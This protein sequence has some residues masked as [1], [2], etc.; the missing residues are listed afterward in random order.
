M[1]S[2]SPRVLARVG[3]LL[4]LVSAWF[5][6][7]GLRAQQGPTAI[8]VDSIV[9]EGNERVAESSILV[10]IPFAAGDTISR[11]DIQDAEQ[12]LWGLGQFDDIRVQAVGGV[13]I[14][15]VVITFVVEERPLVRRV[16]F[17]GLERADAGTVRD[18]AGLADGRPL[19]P[20]AILD[21]RAVILG[22]LSNQGIPFARVE[23]RL[24]PVEG[25]DNVVDL[26]FE[27]EEGN[28]VAVRQIVVEGNES[29][30]E[31]D[32]LGALSTGEEGFWWFQSGTFDQDRYDSDLQAA[33]PDL[34]RSRG[35]L[36]FQ[37][38]SDTLIVDPET[39]KARVEIQVE[40]GEQYR[41]ASLRIDGNR[42]FDDE[43]LEQFFLPQSGGL[44]QSLGFGGSVR[45]EEVEGR[46]FDAVAFDAAQ[47]SIREL[48]ANEGYIFADVQPSVVKGPPLEEGGD[49]TVSIGVTVQEGQ[50][51]F[52]NRILIEGNDYTYER[53]IRDRIALL[54]GD[55]YSQERVIQSYQ[56]IAGLGFF[57]TPLPIPDIR[58]NPETGEVDVTF[59]VVERQTGSVNFGT[60]VGG[61]VGLS[62]FIGYDQPNLFGQA[63]SGSL[64]WDF[65]RFL[66]NFTVSYTDPSIY[67]SRISGTISLFNSRDRFFQFASGQ[68]RRIGG[69]LRFGFP[70]PRARWTRVLVGYSI[71]R[72]ELELFQGV[73]DT[74]LFGRPPG[75]QS[76][77]S[78]GVARSTLNSP[79][80]PS[81]G[82]R[83]TWTTE[84]N[85]GILGG[86]GEFI[87]H[88]LESSWWLPVLELGG[89]GGG[90][91][92]IFALG[93]SVRAGAIFGDAGAFPFDRFW[94]GGV[95]FGQ[96]LRGYDETSVTPLGFFPERSAAISDID[97][98]G[99][100][101]I[102][103]TTEF[104][105]RLNDNISVQTFFDAGNVWTGPS[106][107]N[108]SQ[109]FRGAGV[110]VQLVT[111]FGP[112][113]LD[114]AYG[115]DK[116][117]PGWQLHFR[118]G[119]GF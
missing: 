114:Y 40:E 44:L 104:A 66:N 115:F 27:V 21:A 41:V 31:E 113:G 62:G 105:L 63:K 15:P 33:L 49:P 14:A 23:D 107:I 58:P 60:S 103:V 16:V 77:L 67:Q 13:G 88:S 78:I 12:A 95:Q 56:A 93:T 85:G 43:R 20:Q 89:G 22:E 38:L 17:Q 76:Q 98:L 47:Q 55:V 24:E 72:T 11:E 26:V 99:D 6:P 18:S 61:G 30:P 65:G 119:P 9:V 102:T 110:G 32:I 111:P 51:A 35:F 5:C 86:D 45:E 29:I 75:T 42:E 90:R 37:V 101:F 73:D 53:V 39:G 50:P 94:M 19:N 69:S 57:E 8:V 97:R 52:I 68:R 10:Q 118:M 7:G 74:S 108:P 25:A 87:K 116:A 4:F 36:D 34:Y 84:L 106:A 79:I 83:Q 59:R 112:I 96:Q 100:A 70:L 2:G 117:N 28:R 82:S 91:P 1:K 54:P 64:R 46:V 3:F 81:Q 71:S 92:I 109:L 80:F 48:Y